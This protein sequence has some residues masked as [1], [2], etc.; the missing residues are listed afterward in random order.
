MSKPPQRTRAMHDPRRAAE[1][2]FKSATTKPPEPSPKSP[3]VPNAKELVTLRID[4][5]VLEHFREE[6]PGWQ[7]RI[8]AALRAAAKIALALAV[9]GAPAFPGPASAQTGDRI[10]GGTCA[11]Y[12][13]A[14]QAAPGLASPAPQSTVREKKDPAMEAKVRDYCTQN[15]NASVMEAQ[16]KAMGY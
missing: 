8:N 16:R 1:A 7:D 6:G 9:W 11:D 14:D 15:P 4:R 10:T 2:A 13:K 3:P 12:L 5:D